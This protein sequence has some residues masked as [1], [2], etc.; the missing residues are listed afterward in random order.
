V[1]NKYQCTF[2]SKKCKHGL[3]TYSCKECRQPP[4]NINFRYSD[5][6]SKDT[7]ERS[8]EK[9]SDEKLSDEEPSDGG[10]SDEE[11]S[12]EEMSDEEPSDK[13]MSDDSSLYGSPS[14]LNPFGLQYSPKIITRSSLSLSPSLSPSRSRSLSP[15]EEWLIS[16]KNTETTLER[17]SNFFNCDDNLNSWNNE[18]FI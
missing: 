15:N 16:N 8:D 12:D 6:L 3:I 13:E 9:L 2:C 1:K 11:M 10:P 17:S 5:D 7:K 18:L 14:G 4:R